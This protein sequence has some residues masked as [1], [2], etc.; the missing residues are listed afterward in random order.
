M[1]VADQVIQV[2]YMLADLLGR[3][4]GDHIWDDLRDREET[5]DWP[6]GLEDSVFIRRLPKI[7]HRMSELPSLSPSCLSLLG[8]KRRRSSAVP[9][10]LICVPD[11]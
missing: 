6:C 11:T 4:L 1:D 7:R 9:A 2:G 5:A 10:T 3:K 8:A